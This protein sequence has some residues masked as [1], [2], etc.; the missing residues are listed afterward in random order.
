MTPPLFG[1]IA[2]QEYRNK[3]TTRIFRDAPR[4]ENENRNGKKFFGNK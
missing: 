3:Q 2:G 4:R 1:Y